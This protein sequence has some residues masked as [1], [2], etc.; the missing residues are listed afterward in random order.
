MSASFDPYDVPLEQRRIGPLLALRAG[1]DA[2]RPFLTV[3]GRTW[4]FA[5]ADKECRA[6]G[7]GLIARKVAAQECVAIMLPNCAEMVFTWFACALVRA[8][9]VPINP[10]LRGA[11]LETP[12]RDSA[13]RGLVIHRDFVAAIETLSDEVRRRL[14]WVAVVGGSAGL[15]L[16]AGPAEYVDFDRLCIRDGPDPER[17]ADFRDL[18]TVFYT[19]GT[20]GPAKGVQT[21]NAHQFSAA[22]GFL[23]AVGLER[24]DILFTPFP[25]FHGL[26]ARLGVL[27]CLLVGAHAVVGSRFSATRFWEEVAACKA[28]VAHTIFSTPRLLLER[29]AGRHDRAHR[30]RAMFNAHANP[31]FEERF[32]VTLVEAFSMTE[33]GFVLYTRW[34]DRRPGSCGRVH[35]DWEA[36]LLDDKDRAVKRGEPGQLAV[37][38]KLPYIMMQGYMKQPGATVAAF[39]N[40]W[41]HTGDMMRQDA[42]GYFYYLDRAKERIRRRG[43]NISS[44]DIEQT[45]S[46]HPAIEECAALP[47]PAGPDDDDVRLVAVRRAGTSLTEADYFAWLAQRLP[48]PMLPRYIEFMASLPHTATNKIEKVKLISAGLGASAWENRS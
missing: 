17:E 37:R 2:E 5:E 18:Q 48:R 10:A 13:A 31:A 47:H 3:G 21:I 7:R 16:P 29:P 6:V 11:M 43:E 38:P 26:A 8:V 1:A 15:Q 9:N 25:L 22:S 4:T 24:E 27:P 23:R 40:L 30:L 46:D 20:T 32:G 39:R 35:E 28:T 41:F 33:T 14:E 42:D 36:V 44:H 45:A 19:S 12:F 34:P